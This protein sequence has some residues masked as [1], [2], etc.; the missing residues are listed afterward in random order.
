MDNF[1]QNVS[2]KTLNP[3]E[4]QNI[5]KPIDIT[6]IEKALK[7]LN[8]DSSPGHDGITMTFYLTFFEEIKHT[9]LEFFNEC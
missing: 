1:L 9:L 3:V 5:D 2:L 4:K 6:E 7:N 8:K